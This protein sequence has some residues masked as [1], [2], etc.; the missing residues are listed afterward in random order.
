VIGFLA[1]ALR[2][3]PWR[4]GTLAL[5][6]LAAAVAFVLLT[7]SAATSGLRIKGTLKSSFRNAY[8]ILVRP[9][10]SITPLERQQGLVRPNFLSGIY[11]GIT[12]KQY[13]QIEQIPGVAVAA[14]IANVG[15]VLVEQQ[16]K[17]SLKRLLGPQTDQL[18]RVRFSWVA[19]DGLSHYP[20]ADEYLYA[21]RRRLGVGPLDSMAARD[22]LT[23]KADQVCEGYNASRPLVR[24][25]F[26]PI[27]SS[28][29]RCASPNL[30]QALRNLGDGGVVLPPVVELS[31]ELPLNIS[32]IDPEAETKLVGLRGAMVSGSYL[33]SLARPRLFKGSSTAWR[34]IPVLAASRSFVD[35]QLEAQIERLVV[36]AR[37]DVPAM[38]GAGA[39]GMNDFP[40]GQGCQT[41]G[42]SP[43]SLP[44][45]PGPPGN[46]H[47]TAYRWLTG[48]R[49]IKVGRR[50][51]DAQNLYAQGL[52]RRSTFEFPQF[53]I[54]HAYWRGAPVHYRRLA[55][56]SLE[57][58]R[59]KNGAAAWQDQWEGVQSQSGYLP[60]P[61]DNRDVQ[62]RKV[63]DTQGS[64]GL[65][66]TSELSVPALRVVGL[67]DPDR[68][69]GF[70]PLS[71]VPL[72]TYYP[73]ALDPGNAESRK[74]LHGQP[75]LPSQNIGDYLQ[76]PPLLLTNLRGLQP[77]LSNARF[78]G[79]SPRQQHAP[80]S[81]IRVR[82][83]DVTGT[84]PLS[85]LR[86]RTVAQQ[87]HAETG[88]QVDI[89]AGSSPHPVNITLPAG[90]FGR[91]KLLLSEGWSKK[92]ATIS[93][94]NALDRKD[95]ALFALVLVVCCFFLANSSLAAVRARRTEIGT[96]RTL[97]WPG[98]AIFTA[99]LGELLVVAAGAG[100]AGTGIAALLVS[101]F[102]LHVPL[103]RIF[104]VLPLAIVLA[105]I[106]GVGPAW[107][108]TRGE[109][110]DAVRPPVVPGRRG[111]A[112]GLVP[113]ALLN[114]R[115]LPLRSAIAAGGLALGVA[116]LTFLIGIERGFH[117]ALL[118]TLL[119]NAVSI[120]VRRP[121]LVAA[122]IT[123]AL[124]ALAVADV[125][126]LNLRERAPELATLRATGWRDGHIVLL[127]LLE[128]VGLGLL[129][130]AVGLGI[131]LLVGTELLPV[132]VQPLLAAA[133]IAAGAGV[134]AALIAATLPTAQALRLQPS[135]VL[136]VE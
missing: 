34:E 39:C 77:L 49:G 108:A 24:A 10:G 82:V 104:Y 68:L 79:I 135:V 133:G 30:T 61:T 126:Y 83:K 8:D 109:P 59:M 25:P 92:G 84:D 14:P 16:I 128:G 71:R 40:G 88:L 9:K 41:T 4:A 124:A 129:G 45:E 33:S 43:H 29:L 6:I 112:R 36:P 90:K 125:L 69:R 1:S 136:A 22:P 27:N 115:R 97:G 98:R 66:N 50:S 54:V 100:L 121:D 62:F 65:I 13:H 56:F 119:G 80:I 26:A 37:T 31:F 32:A 38:V 122:G 52:R 47:T 51:F 15:T 18:F 105:L 95:L 44:K 48:L 117:G 91:P 103:S 17:V 127:I 23:G 93:Y 64:L 5:G 55:D 63:S 67:F 19:Q 12:L 11:G 94:I 101:R 70:S 57:P 114:L 20:A 96:L 110:L 130:S 132:P 28:R 7:G 87:I 78:T 89:T 99:I 53:Q 120:Q 21:T 111:H 73:P 107:E 116:A 81:E 86:I 74:L 102:A 106:A 131:G 75:L 123:I 85:R 2:N 60:Q 58:L 72:E 118:G 134:G 35:E 46:R 113:L 3:R 76:Q 42:P